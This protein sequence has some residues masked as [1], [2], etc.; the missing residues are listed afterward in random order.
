MSEIGDVFSI[1][2][3]ENKKFKKQC[4]EENIQK[5]NKFCEENKEFSHKTHTDCRH[6]H[7][8]KNNK[9]ICTVYLS[10]QKFETVKKKYLKY[11]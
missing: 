1:L 10:K 8:F 6:T 5:L 11:K 9:K 2:K 7:I 4:F 3:E